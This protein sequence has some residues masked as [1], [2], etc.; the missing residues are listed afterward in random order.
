MLFNSYS[1]IFLFLPVTLLGFHLAGKR[2]FHR[3][4]VSWLIGASLFFYGWW[5]PI[6]LWLIVGS[7]LVNYLTGVSLA[8]KPRKPV[9]VAGIFANLSLLGYFKYANFFLDNINSLTGSN[10]VLNEVALPLAISFFTFQQIAYLVDVY[11]EETRENNFLHYCLF[12]TFFP[13]LIAGPIVHHKEMLPQFARD[14]FHRIRAKHL[15]VGLSIFLVGLFKK[16]VFADGIALNAS[17]VFEAAERGIALTFFEAWGGSLAYTFQLY[18]DFSGYSDM[19]IGSARMF[20][21]YLP[22]N[23]N[24]PYKATSIIDFWKRWHITL[25]RFLRDYLYIPL[26][27]NRK[28]KIRLFINLMV[29]ALI[30]G[31]WHGAGW[32]FVLWGGLQGIYL[33][34]NHNWQ[35]ISKT[36]RKLKLNS[37]FA[38]AVTMLAIVVS[39]VPFRAASLDGAIKVYEGMLG[40]NGISLPGVFKPIIEPI[41]AIFPDISVVAEGFNSFGSAYGLAALFILLIVVLFSPNTMEWMQL[42]KPALGFEHFEDK[43]AKMGWLMW[44][45]NIVWAI[46]VGFIAVYA[47]LQMSNPSEFLYFAF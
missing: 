9:L 44:K 23:F 37:L 36:N 30:G 12:V 2:G 10:I 29:T 1:F 6:Y 38:W 26:G 24:S 33:V 21:I 4:A 7:V 14:V 28:G 5:N 45:P 40:M 18:F 35:K 43:D 17:P 13:Q 15:A 16:V 32:T 39:W 20:G 41:R 22:I 3:I 31:L 46:L 34:I 42:Y 8:G 11:R 27:G 47:L 25:S 19:A